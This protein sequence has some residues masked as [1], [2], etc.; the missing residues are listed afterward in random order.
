M[1]ILGSVF[2][3]L[4]QEIIVCLKYEASKPKWPHT[5]LVCLVHTHL[6][7]PLHGS[8]NN[9]SAVVYT[10]TR[11]APEVKSLLLA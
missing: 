4:L 6:S 8:R 7:C 1:K 3:E 5:C 9:S 11:T 10:M 2:M